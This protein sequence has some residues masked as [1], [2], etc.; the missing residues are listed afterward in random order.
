MR[1]PEPLSLDQVFG[2]IRHDLAL[3]G[4]PRPQ[5]RVVNNAGD[6]ALVRRRAPDSPRHPTAPVVPAWP[7][8]GAAAPVRPAPRVPPP[9]PLPRWHSLGIAAVLACQLLVGAWASA[10]RLV[11][12]LRRDAGVAIDHDHWIRD[13]FFLALAASLPLAGRIGDQWGR[14]NGFLG[15][16]VLFTGANALGA[17]VP[18]GAVLLTAQ[19]LQGA[20]AAF[21]TVNGVALVVGRFRR[22]IAV[23]LWGATTAAGPALGLVLSWWL[24]HTDQ[25][26]TGSVWLAVLTV[27]LAALG[28]Y[29]ADPVEGVSDPEAPT[30]PYPRAASSGRLWAA[31]VAVSLLATSLVHGL[32]R[33]RMSLWED[34]TGWLFIAFACVAGVG[35]TILARRR[36]GGART[37]Y[38]LLA[39]RRFTGAWVAMTGVVSAI[40]SMPLFLSVYSSNLDF[41]A[42]GAVLGHLLPVPLSALL[43]GLLAP[44]LRRRLGTTAT[45]VA[46]SVSLSVGLLVLGPSGYDSDWITVPLLL[47]TGAG[48][49]LALA[50]LAETAFAEVSFAGLGP[51]AVLLGTGLWVATELP[52]TVF[53]SVTASA[54]W[55]WGLSGE[56][57]WEA[58]RHVSSQLM[59]LGAVLSLSVAAIAVLTLRRRAERALERARR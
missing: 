16:T 9:R 38:S 39:G 12:S 57:Y 55:R 4:F 48:A 10:N 3:G 34:L 23:G 45:V 31:T 46:G 40:V 25:Y 5:R 6:L 19:A 58:F 35:W 36:R 44:L 50:V 47:L 53:D 29:R 14:R 42:A 51:A 43:S 2:E 13:A 20:G 30:D 49:G 37:P 59:T 27:L 21:T 7:D 32:A 11:T 28:W 52:V 33:M 17:L 1:R 56:A 15:G 18:H 41:Q 8:P 26:T 54:L 22:P 24:V